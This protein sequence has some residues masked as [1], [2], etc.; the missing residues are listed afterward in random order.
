M[1]NRRE[2]IKKSVLM[3]SALAIS[4]PWARAKSIQNDEPALLFL[5]RTSY[6]VKRQDYKRI[7]SIGI[8]AYLEEQLNPEAIADPEAERKLLAL[9]ILELDR[10]NL[11][12]LQNSGSRTY[13]AL[14]KAFILRRVYS[15][16]QLLEKM[17]EFWSDH[18]NIPSEV[19]S[20]EIVI[21]QREV[22]RKNAL[23]NFKKM[24][25]ATA[26]SPAMLRYLDNENNIAEH[27]NENYARELMELHSLGVDGGYSE[28]DVKE[29]ARAFSG[30]STHDGTKD[31]FIFNENEHDKD[32]KLVLGHHLPANRGIEDGLHV[33]NIL[34]NH[35]S[36]ARHIAFKL[37]R[38]FISD[39]PPESIIN[40]LA[41]V[42][43]KEKAEIRPIL[44]TLFSS[45]EFFASTGQKLRRPLDFLIAGLRA[46][47]SEIYEYW[48]LEQTLKEIDQLPY[49]WHPPDGYPDVAAKWAS[50][51]GLLQ[52]WKLANKLTY[53]SSSTGEYG[54]YGDL[55][56]NH[57]NLADLK[58]VKDLVAE[59]SEQVFGARLNEDRL[60]PFINF[61]SDN[62]G[63]DEPVNKFLI[64][65]KLASL[66][67]LMLSSKEFQWT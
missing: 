62:A 56:A 55:M 49:G 13:K 19:Q 48:L 20:E 36:T 54:L 32:A 65:R 50:T 24:L 14:I 44:R 1:L 52:R 6:G 58:T 57:K 22:I 61:A 38:R 39:K 53:E 11:Y 3:T 25:F 5:K 9:S 27:P 4:T 60:E 66:Y 41:E 23:G 17:V 35:P 46:T 45:E 42:Y 7:N 63:P 34:A 64:A 16:K 15:R 43:I 8:K 47:N 12:G 59:V 2:F 26:K 21:F 18:F 51:S 67:S 33:L 29:V 40:K 10:H 30:W 37:A 31:G 28:K